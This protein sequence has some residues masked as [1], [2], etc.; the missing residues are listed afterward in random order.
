MNIPNYE[1]MNL[2]MKEIAKS[3]YNEENLKAEYFNSYEKYIRY[4]MEARTKE[5]VDDLSRNTIK[6]IS[7]YW[8]E[9][10]KLVQHFL[11]LKWV[12]EHQ[13]NIENMLNYWK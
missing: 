3:F 2:K 9:R 7:K 4:D 10:S 6:N 11:P 12:I 8:R 5:N 13:T 1:K